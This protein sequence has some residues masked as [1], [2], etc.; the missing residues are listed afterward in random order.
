MNRTIG[1]SPAASVAPCAKRKEFRFG[2]RSR[3]PD[4]TLLRLKEM[5]KPT[6]DKRQ[7]RW[8]K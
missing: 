6:R 2:C 8:S 3:W 5:K 7:S 4:D 1:A